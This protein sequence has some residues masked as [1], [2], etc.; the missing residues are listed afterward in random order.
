MKCASHKT[1]AMMRFFSSAL[2]V[3]QRRL[4]NTQRT[5]D[6][7]IAVRLLSKH[8]RPGAI[9]RR[10][11]ARPLAEL[12]DGRHW[13]AAIH[14]HRPAARLVLRIPKVAHYPHEGSNT[15]LATVKGAS[16]GFEPLRAILEDELLYILRE[17]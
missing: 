4:A 3:K 14:N 9:A 7:R 8:D 13:L 11:R 16:T 15:G 1:A 10:E 6:R 17:A 12:S 5:D 2:G